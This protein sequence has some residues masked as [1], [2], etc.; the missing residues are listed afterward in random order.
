MENAVQFHQQRLSNGLNIIGE[1]NPAA[2]SAAVGFFVKTGAR[3]E[4]PEVNGVT[5]FLEHMVFKG[6]ERRSAFDVNKDFDA[7]GANYNAYT[8]EE[9]TVFHAAILPEYLPQ[10][11]DILADIL[12]PSLRNEDF[13]MEKNVI[14][15]EIGMYDDQPMWATYEAAKQAFFAG[16]PLGGSVLGTKESIAALK[17]DQM[18]EY[19]E[20]R[21]V[22]PNISVVATGNYDWKY[23]VQLV[24]ER[25]ESWKS[26][27]ASRDLAAARGADG[28]QVL[29]KEKV[30]QEHIFMLAPGPAADSP[31]RY[32]AEILANILGD[33]TASRLYWGLVDP[34]IVDSADLSFHEYEGTGAF[35]GY[36]SGEPDRAQECLNIACRILKEAQKNGITEEEL[37]QAKSKLGSRIVRGGE[38]PMGRMQAL[39][40]SW[41]YLKQ[42]RT[43]DD[44]LQAIDAVTTKSVRQLL[45]RFPL[46]RWTI[47]AAGPVEKLK[48]P[49]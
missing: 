41:T 6:T 10:A 37:Q 31:D 14:I 43:V 19:F 34:G 7:I 36:L 17:R 15:E 29:H 28:F 23:L 18:N 48:R 11:V 9:N 26:G 20:R 12:R 25:C 24:Q 49:N 47:V 1:T 42:Y 22:A 21:Y 13:D 40:F 45:D 38:R 4:T 3:D 32:S 39:G 8:S 5:H 27:P 16:H 2:R 46:E 44:D 30:A 33:D 35:Y